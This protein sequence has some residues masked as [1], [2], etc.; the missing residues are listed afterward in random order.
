LLIIYRKSDGLICEN[1]GMNSLF[2]LGV[3]ETAPI[4]DNVIARFGGKRMDYDLIRIHD[5]DQNEIANKALTHECK[6]ENGL[7]VFGQKI[8][9][10]YSLGS[11]IQEKLLLLKGECES[12]IESGFTSSNGHTY[13]TNRDDQINFIG[14]KDRLASDE[15]ITTIPWKTEDAGYINHSR[16]E[17]MQVYYE[18]FDHKQAQLLKYD[19]LKQQVEAAQTVEELDNINW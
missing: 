16:E 17:W 5:V 6:V 7:L 2:P 4:F 1:Q 13:R 8:D 18:A 14:Q 3:T 15:S 11:A 10:E 19:Q 12:E 9:F